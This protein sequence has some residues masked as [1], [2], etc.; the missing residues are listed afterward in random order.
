MEERTSGIILRTRLLTET[1]LIVQWLTPDLGRIST[2]AKGAR[3][4][5]S[6]FLGK[7]DLFYE[8]DFSFA[9]SRRSEL[10]NLREV[11]VGNPNAALRHELERLQQASYFAVLLEKSTEPEAPIRELYEL[12]KQALEYLGGHPPI[13][14]VVLGFELKLLCALGYEPDLGGLRASAR[15]GAKA[16]LNA[17]LGISVRE[18]S[19]LETVAKQEL[20][21]FLQRAIGTA[22][23]RVP[24]QRAA[25]LGE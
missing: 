9:R 22:L 23:E 11:S 17:S 7:L 21:Q 18:V 6:A 24:S 20:N 3:R 15:E 12:L 19:L 10:H 25:A 14:E 4:P 13:P 5:K 1:S 8:A 2:V 16:A